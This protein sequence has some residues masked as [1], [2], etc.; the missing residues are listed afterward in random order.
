[1]Y[2]VGDIIIDGFIETKDICKKI[3]LNKNDNRFLEK[4]N[5]EFL[6]IIRDVNSNHLEVVNS[7]FASPIVLYS[8]DENN[9]ILSNNLYFLLKYRGFK[10][11]IK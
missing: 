5:S 3:I 9:F 1:M 8:F 2:F 7:R 11:F 4:F 6:I 10:I